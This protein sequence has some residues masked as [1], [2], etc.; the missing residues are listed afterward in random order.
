MAE[1]LVLNQ[2]RAD[3]A[4]GDVIAIHEDGEG[5]SEAERN[6]P[7][8]TIVS[9][10]GVPASTFAAYRAPMPGGE[11]LMPRSWRANRRLRASLRERYVGQSAARRVCSYD[12]AGPVD[13]RRLL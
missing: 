8:F 5:W 9:H 1:L 6:S 13:K 10:P 12:P 2:D 11:S 7:L 4:A 3:F